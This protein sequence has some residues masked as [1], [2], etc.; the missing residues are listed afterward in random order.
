VSDERKETIRSKYRENLIAKIGLERV[1]WLEGPHEPK[2]YRIE[3]LK[4][5]RD[6][7]RLKLK[8]EQQKVT[9]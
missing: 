2:R 5:I 8:E 1:E 6:T 7:Y 4:E 9:R 3:D